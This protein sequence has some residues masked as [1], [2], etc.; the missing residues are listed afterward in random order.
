MTPNQIIE[1]HEKWPR[2]TEHLIEAYAFQQYQKAVKD[3]IEMLGSK[4]EV[5]NTETVLIA[6][7]RFSFEEWNDYKYSNYKLNYLQNGKDK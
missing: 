6:I 7:S 5:P 4:M 3:L 1:R 2:A